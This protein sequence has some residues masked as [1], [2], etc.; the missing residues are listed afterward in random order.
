MAQEGKEALIKD[1]IHPGYVTA[2]GAAYQ[3]MLW[4]KQPELPDEITCNTGPPR[5]GHDEL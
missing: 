1:S 4:G 3:A 5:F 2:V